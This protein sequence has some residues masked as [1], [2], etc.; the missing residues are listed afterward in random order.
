MNLLRRPTASPKTWATYLGATLGVALLAQR[1]LSLGFADML[2]TSDPRAALAWNSRNPTAQALIAE[3]QLT[4]ADPAHARAAAQT[5]A[6]LIL[7]D[8]LA[9]GGLSYFGVAVAQGGDPVRAEKILRLAAARQPLDLAAHSWLFERAAQAKDVSAALAELDVLLRGRPFLAERAEF[10]VTRLLAA[11]AAAEAGLV[12]LLATAPPWRPILLER[13][14]EKLDDKDALIR[15]YSQLQKSAAPPSAS[16]IRALLDRLAREDRVDEAYLLWLA[17]LPPDRL[18]R[19]GLLYNGDFAFPPSDLAFD[20]RTPAIRGAAASVRDEGGVKAL[21]IEFYGARVNFEH[22]MHLLN[23]PPGG[24]VLAGEASS[25]GLETERGLRWRVSCFPTASGALGASEF[26][27]GERAWKL[28]RFAFAVPAE[29]CSA[30]MLTLELPA[31]IAA[32]MQISG[33]AGYRRL[34]IEAAEPVAK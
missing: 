14:S 2:A 33:T 12:R 4:S 8:P 19:L 20:W 3:R 13:L 15:L 29:G 17:S 32:E 25:H 6:G 27:K 1:I 11:E 16:E 24:Y 21:K 28:F 7:R 10:F 31:R 30:Q 23:L 26:F 9:P 22:V 34:S 18:S 5:A